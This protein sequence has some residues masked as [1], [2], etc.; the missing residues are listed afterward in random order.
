M[1]YQFILFMCEIREILYLI[2]KPPTQQDSDGSVE[3]MVVVLFCTVLNNWGVY[4]LFAS[5]ML[6]SQKLKKAVLSWAFPPC[7]FWLNKV[8][9]KG[10]I[11]AI[12]VDLS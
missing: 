1:I 3:Q 4:W 11:Y 9:L 7:R 6:A 10:F 5:E 12:T 2:V 8:V